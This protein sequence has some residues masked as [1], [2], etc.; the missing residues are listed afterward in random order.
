LVEIEQLAFYSLKNNNKNSVH[1]M[2]H[3]ACSLM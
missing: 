1:V 2:Y 3:I